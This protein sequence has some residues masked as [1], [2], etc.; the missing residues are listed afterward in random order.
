MS[1]QIVRVL[2]LWQVYPHI[3]PPGK[4]ILVDADG[5]KKT[6]TGWLPCHHA[7]VQYELAF[8]PNGDIARVLWMNMLRN[9][10]RA[11]VSAAGKQ[12]DKGKLAPMGYTKEEY[13]KQAEHAYRDQATWTVAVM[14]P[15]WRIYDMDIPRV[16]SA[17]THNP[18]AICKRYSPACIDALMY[19]PDKA[20]AA[21]NKM[22]KTLSEPPHDDLNGFNARMKWQLDTRYSTATREQPPECV[23][24]IQHYQNM[25]TTVDE[26]EHAKVLKDAFEDI[27]EVWQGTPCQQA[28][29]DR[30]VVVA[31]LEEAFALKC[32]VKTDIYMMS[33][34]FQEEDRKQ[35]G[36]P[37]IRVLPKGARIAIPWAHRWGIDKWMAL[38]DFQPVS[39]MCIGRLDQY[40]V[41]RGQL[42]RQ[43]LDAYPSK[44]GHHFKMN[45]VE[46]VST[47]DVAAFVK[48]LDH[49]F[50]MNRVEMVSTD[51]VAAFVKQLNYPVI[52]CFSE[53]NIEGIDTG[54][55][56]LS[57]PRRIRTLTTRSS[58]KPPRLA[59]EE[60]AF[61]LQ[62]GEN[63]SV[64]NV[65]SV[66]TP[67]D[68][69]VYI[70]Q[71][72]TKPFDIHV[73]R[74]LCRHKLFIVNCQ[75]VPFMW[76]AKVPART[77]ISP[78][79]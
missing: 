52:Q 70:C 8:K 71:A 27:I 46:M 55:R 73:A 72:N 43:M 14:Y 65:R 45:R 23:P 35:M 28:I 56:W 76:E 5:K 77:A 42:F 51:D 11:P 49:H 25:W 61:T 39:M 6:C 44:I 54:R 30:L 50:K 68:V 16:F 20:L 62:V 75:N 15:H 18:E 13:F 31:T 69:G 60:E 9:K 1:W 26:I 4:F 74:S 59:L 21:V 63:A 33:L 66:L 10:K 34:P 3:L 58:V 40:A 22:L 53:E 2:R 48:Q 17:L 19:A 47:D 57:R 38:A 41:G 79:I 78:F 29:G 67:V 32:F 7:N 36:L 24:D 37:G 12:I 64:V